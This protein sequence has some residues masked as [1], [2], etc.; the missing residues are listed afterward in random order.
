M[1]RIKQI[2]KKLLKIKIISENKT[3]SFLIT[4]TKLIKNTIN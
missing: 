1:F 3:I 2:F 4:K